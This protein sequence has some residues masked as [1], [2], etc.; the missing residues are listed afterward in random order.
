MDCLLDL[1]DLSQR[2]FESLNAEA[3]ASLASMEGLD[4]PAPST[5]PGKPGAARWFRPGY[6]AATLVAVAA[7]GLHGFAVGGDRKGL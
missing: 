7:V 2:Y 3:L 1:V 6:L 4:A 5:G